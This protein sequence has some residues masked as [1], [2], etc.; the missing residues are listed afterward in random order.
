MKISKFYTKKYEKSPV[1]LFLPV[2]LINSGNNPARSLLMI[3]D[4]NDKYKNRKNEK[5]KK[6]KM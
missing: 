1:I 4:N 5:K 2:L 6:R 3:C